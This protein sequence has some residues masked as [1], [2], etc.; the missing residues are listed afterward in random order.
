MLTRS[1]FVNLI[2]VSFL[3]ILPC[4]FPGA[5][6][7]QQMTGDLQIKVVDSLGN[8]IPDVNA[9]ITGPQIHGISGG[10]RFGI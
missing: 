8:A 7:A 9:T 3:L 6:R 4:L 2:I 10:V 5:V 1:A